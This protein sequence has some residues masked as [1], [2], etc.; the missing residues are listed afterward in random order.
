MSFSF[1]GSFF[2]FAGSKPTR[3]TQLR[4]SPNSDKSESSL[5]FSSR[6]ITS[7]TTFFTV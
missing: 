3:H 6:K 7:N 1:G 5:R 2:S 4:P